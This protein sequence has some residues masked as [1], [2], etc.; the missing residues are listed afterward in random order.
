MLR[1]QMERHRLQQDYN[2]SII[3]PHAD[4]YALNCCVGFDDY[5]GLLCRYVLDY[6][7]FNFCLP[8]ASDPQLITYDELLI[9][10]KNCRKHKRWKHSAVRFEINL[11]DNLYKL[12][13]ELNNGTYKISKSNVFVVMDPKY[14]EVFAA[15]FRDRIVH[16]LLMNRMTEIFE[17]YFG[18][19]SYNCRKGRGTL[20]AAKKLQQLM[21]ENPD[22]YILGL[23]ISA[24][25]PSINKKQ[26]LE[27]IL[28]FIDVQYVEDKELLKH[29]FKLILNNDVTWNCRIIGNKNDW[30]RVPKEKS[31][32]GR[33]TGIPIGDLPSQFL[34]NFVLTPIDMYIE[35]HGFSSVRYVDDLRIIGNKQDILKLRRDIFQYISGV[36][37]QF[38]PNKVYAQQ[39]SK[40][41]KF[42]GYFITKNYM[43]PGKRT[44][45]RTYT[46]GRSLWKYKPIQLRATAN[47][48]LGLLK[49]CVSYTVKSRLV[50]AIT[51]KYKIFTTNNELSKIICQDI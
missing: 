5:W 51:N 36:H 37:L 43:L 48:Y 8:V 10:Y 4:G 16:H 44:K 9:A 29:L 25:F 33:S 15:D 17:S 14:R 18:D 21:K 49:H 39:V 24:F 13:T 3:S 27:D 20:A 6:D 42:I 30:K 31:L 12:L 19:T 23:D 11:E 7:D 38:N 22:K 45:S 2:S 26:L 41:C 46:L 35:N 34:A 47:S 32:F 28:R 1:D 50:T 40:G